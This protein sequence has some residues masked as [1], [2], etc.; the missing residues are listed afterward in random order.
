ML[1]TYFLIPD[2]GRLGTEI[3]KAKYGSASQ[4]SHLRACVV[5]E[6]VWKPVCNVI[7][8]K[9]DLT[10]NTGSKLEKLIGETEK[11][12]LTSDIYC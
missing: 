1:L 9:Y 4:S 7:R 10:D 11:R 5:R 8:F 6:P 3:F 2:N 12:S